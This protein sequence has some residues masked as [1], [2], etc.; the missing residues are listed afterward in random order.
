MA[1]TKTRPTAESVDKFVNGIADEQRRRDCFQVLEIMKKVTKLEPEMWGTSIVGFGR[2]NYK[3]ESG[4]KGEWFLVGFSPRKQDLT[5]YL[6]SGLDR[7]KDLLT[8]LGKHKTGRACLYIKNLDDVDQATLK[9]LIKQ[10]VAD[11]KAM[12]K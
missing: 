10:S 7:Y 11:T 12:K 5:L 1:E 8:K 4:T 3:Y 6:M 2:Y 9:T